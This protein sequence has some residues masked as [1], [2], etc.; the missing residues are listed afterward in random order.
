MVDASFVEKMH[1]A[2]RNFCERE[3]DLLHVLALRAIAGQLS[4]S[5]YR[6]AAVP[7]GVGAPSAGRGRV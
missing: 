6:G 2:A 7:G 1:L 3:E 4:P 5:E